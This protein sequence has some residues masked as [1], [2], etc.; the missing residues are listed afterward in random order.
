MLRANLHVHLHLQARGADFDCLINV[1]GHN[2]DQKVHVSKLATVSAGDRTKSDN[3][4]LARDSDY[5]HR[6]VWL[7]DGH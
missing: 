3:P 1:H 6:R 4:W 7:F 5:G 2:M